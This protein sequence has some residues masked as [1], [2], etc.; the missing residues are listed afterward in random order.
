MLGSF[1]A[2]LLT[3]FGIVIILTL[4]L[5]ASAF[6]LLLREQQTEAA[7]QRIGILVEPITTTAQR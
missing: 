2:R 6:V 3:G 4:F 1:R 5:S 7:Q